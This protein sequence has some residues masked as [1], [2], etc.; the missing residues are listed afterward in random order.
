MNSYI[1]NNPEDG[2]I[3]PWEKE[4][5]TPKKPEVIDYFK[6]RTYSTLE[7]KLSH[8]KN[9]DVDIEPILSNLTNTSQS[10]RA[11]I[12]EIIR[13]MNYHKKFFTEK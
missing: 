9:N 3:F 1:Q 7:T 8:I 13:N 6:D 2:S 12:R 10:Q 4:K 5:I 11:E